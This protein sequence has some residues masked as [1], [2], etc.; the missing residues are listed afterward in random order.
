MIKIQEIKPLLC[1]LPIIH[2]DKITFEIGNK[3]INIFEYNTELKEI[4]PYLKGFLSVKEITEKLDFENLKLVGQL[5]AFLI[6]KN[7][8]VDSR[9]QFW[10]FHNLTKYPDTFGIE[11]TDQEL[12]KIY[13]TRS[14]HSK[15]ETISDNLIKS[16]PTNKI[17]TFLDI[18]AKRSSVPEFGVESITN[19]QLFGLL[20]SMSVSSIAS[21]GGLYSNEIWI[22]IQNCESV[23]KGL[24]KYQPISQTLLPLDID[25]F[26]SDMQFCFDSGTIHLSGAI[27]FVVCNMQFH[28]QKYSNRGYKFSIMEAGAIGQNAY[29]YC[30]N[31]NLGIYQCGGYREDFVNQKLNLTDYQ[32]VI[33]TIIIG[34]KLNGIRQ[35]YIEEK[36][37]VD[38]QKQLEKDLVNK[39]IVTKIHTYSMKSQNKENGLLKSVASYKE[40]SGIIATGHATGETTSLTKLKAMAEA[41]ERHQSGDFFFDFFGSSDE[42]TKNGHQFLDVQKYLKLNSQ[43]QDN[44]GLT[45][46]D[47]TTKK[48]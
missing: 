9:Q 46:F 28:T 35:E 30:A 17:D 2:T 38:Y 21:T 22:R 15:N 41:F 6:K 5:V 18:C 39:N 47:P 29:L 33:S 12:S 14:Q 40:Q 27:I 8:V 42:I 1:C 24:Y 4:F 11:L 13:D 23:P 34:S 20:Q 45:N 36:A 31:Q 44:N 26:D 32:T 43:Y 48:Y 25:V 10:N 16:N 7:I 37:I 3:K 19:N